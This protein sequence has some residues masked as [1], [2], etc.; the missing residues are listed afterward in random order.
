MTDPIADMFCSVRNALQVKKEAVDISFS[1]VKLA[2]V[3]ILR[4]EGFIRHYEILNQDVNRK[5]IRLALKYR[6]SGDPVIAGIR[7]VSR[8]GCRVY[9]RRC[10]IG[11]VLNGFGLSIISTSKGVMTGWKARINGVGGELIGEVV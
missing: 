3:K 10:D 4:E 6:P 5:V 2:I 9:V 1:I 7:R 11:R 8:P